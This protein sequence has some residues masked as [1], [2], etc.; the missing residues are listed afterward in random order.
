MKT[1]DTNDVDWVFHDEDDDTT[2][3]HHTITRLPRSA[4]PEN[5]HDRISEEEEE[6][7]MKEL[8][9]ADEDKTLAGSKFS[10]RRKVGSFR[11]ATAA[12]DVEMGKMPERGRS[13]SS[14]SILVGN[15]FSRAVRTLVTCAFE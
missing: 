6:F 11:K 13:I 12:K 1:I 2:A 7:D 3:I 4:S 8:G 10:T 5:M 15:F 14:G 9:E